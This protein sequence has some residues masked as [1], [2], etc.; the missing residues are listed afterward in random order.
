MFFAEMTYP[1]LHLSS[2]LRDLKKNA[3][4]P[5]QV[6]LRAEKDKASRDQEVSDRT[7]V[8]TRRV[9]R[10]PAALKR[11]KSLPFITTDSGREM[12]LDF[13]P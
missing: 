2:E 5:L 9:C 10:M 1:K 11:G 8:Q 4:L 3:V 13:S 12:L 6:L 7:H